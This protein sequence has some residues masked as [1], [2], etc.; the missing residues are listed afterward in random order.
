MT[1]HSLA[2]ALKPGEKT[3]VF[4]DGSNLWIASK[5]NNFRVDYQK[6]RNEV[7]THCDLLRIYYYTALLPDSKEENPNPIV[8]IIDFLRYNHYSV[9]TKKAHERTKSNSEGEEYQVVKGNVDIEIAVDMVL[10][11]QNGIEHIVL[12]SGDGDFRR[13]VEYC[14]SQLVKVSVLSTLS[15]NPPMVSNELRQQADYF[16]E[17]ADLRDSI[18]LEPKERG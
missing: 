1:D 10:A 11:S 17:L 14:Q 8:P 13:A 9:I 12:V 4:I 5:M 6:F 7:A 18:K 2:N 15:S 16:I 3:A